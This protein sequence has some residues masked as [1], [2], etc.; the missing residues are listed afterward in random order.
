M[1]IFSLLKIPILSRK[2]LRVGVQSQH[3]HFK[4]TLLFCDRKSNSRYK[5]KELHERCHIHSVHLSCTRGEFCTHAILSPVAC[6]FRKI[7]RHMT[8]DFDVCEIDL[9]MEMSFLSAA[10]FVETFER[11][12]EVNM[13]FIK[14]VDTISNRIER[15]KT[16]SQCLEF[17]YQT[18]VRRKK[19]KRKKNRVTVRAGSFS[20][21][22]CECSSL[23]SLSC[24]CCACSFSLCVKRAVLFV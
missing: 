3:K 2:L 11:R 14:R 8:S 24:I 5:D 1:S 15:C 16:S 7:I 22:A 6:T 4:K 23:D 9:D 10:S 12:G 20:S 21:Q 13:G 18:V 19:K 17:F